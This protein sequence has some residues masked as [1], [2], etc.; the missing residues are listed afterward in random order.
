MQAKTTKK[1]ANSVKK[2]PESVPA[3]ST[4]DAKPAKAKKKVG[5]GGAA[6]S[7]EHAALSKH[8]AFTVQR[9]D[10]S[11]VK[12]A[13][14]NPRKI[15][16]YAREKLLKMLKGHG[17]VETLVWNKTTGNLV[18]GHQRL[19][20]LDDLH[21]G[22]PYSLDFAVVEMTIEEEIQVNMGMNNPYAQ[23]VYDMDRVNDI[24]VEQGDN[25]PEFLEGAGFS[26]TTI[27]QMYLDSG[28]NPDFLD[29]LESST[30]EQLGIEEDVN[31]LLDEADEAKSA[32]VVNKTRGDDEEAVEDLIKQRRAKYDATADS[33]NEGEFYRMLVCSTDRR[34]FNALYNLG[35][36][37]DTK[38][39]GFEEL[40]DAIWNYLSE[41]PDTVDFDDLAEAD[42]P[43]SVEFGEAAEEGSVLTPEEEA[44]FK[45]SKAKPSDAPIK[46]SKK[47]RLK[48]K[49]GK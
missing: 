25:L 40:F 6:E 49:A 34:L 27:E 45:A 19:A 37:T 18:S 21:Q 30:E 7:G 42:P 22:K 28:M 46:L 13:D 23:G 36:D 9:L 11:Q 4:R 32:K 26:L 15:D 33:E 35:L 5:V 12:N 20:L 1:T 44:E 16:K 38:T 29:S 43:D 2:A 31:A 47:D 48:L 39:V 17:L 14:Y 24:V 8:Q 10:R 3:Q 41:H